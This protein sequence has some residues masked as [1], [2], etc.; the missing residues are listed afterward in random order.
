MEAPIKVIF[1]GETFYEWLNAEPDP[2][3]DANLRTYT[4][5]DEAVSKIVDHVNSHGPY[6]GF[7]GFS[8]GGTVCHLL[9]L[10]AANGKLAC[11]P[12]RFLILLSCRMTRHAP[13]QPLVEG[14]RAAPLA[15]PTF[16]MWNGWDDHVFPEET[17]AM[18]AT[19]DAPTTMPM[20]HIKGHKVPPVTAEEARRLRAFL[21]AFPPLQHDFL[22]S[23]RLGMTRCLGAC[24]SPVD[25]GSQLT[26][27]DVPRSGRAGSSIPLV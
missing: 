22:T 24:C 2:G 8:Q 20:A 21:E 26:D 1:A 7:L 27:Q 5:V 25:G 19:L 4:Y 13:H 3:G 23:L 14:A 9:G 6:D 12:P 17:Q 10:L 11:P 18:L 16:V 15:V